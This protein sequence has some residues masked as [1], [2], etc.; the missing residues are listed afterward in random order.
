MMMRIKPILPVLLVLGLFAAPLAAP[1]AAQE[2]DT[3]R[4][5]V[6]VLPR[7]EVYGESFTLGEIAEIDGFDMEVIIPISI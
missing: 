3:G 6:R 2:L 1:L 4:V 7:V 5:E